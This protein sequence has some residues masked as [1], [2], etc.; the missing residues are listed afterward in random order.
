MQLFQK[1]MSFTFVPVDWWR[2]KK[3]CG[4]LTVS[5]KY[6]VDVLTNPLPTCSLHFSNKFWT[7]WPFS[8]RLDWWLDVQEILEHKV[9]LSADK[10]PAREARMNALAGEK[11]CS[12]NHYQTRENPQERSTGNQTSRSCLFPQRLCCVFT[13]IQMDN[14]P[15]A[16]I[17]H[18][19][20]P[21]HSHD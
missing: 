12:V 14:F 13:L 19:N 17:F 21:T 18:S 7:C 5:W 16:A 9:S 6:E 4:A 20:V 2:K 3:N 11:H 15:C 8:T 1:P 10:Q